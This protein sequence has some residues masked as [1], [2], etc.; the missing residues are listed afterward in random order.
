MGR[1]C[2]HA[3][4]ICWL[5]GRGAQRYRCSQHGEGI[6]CTQFHPNIGLV[7]IIQSYN[8]IYVAVTKRSY[9]A[10]YACVYPLGVNQLS[11]SCSTRILFMFVPMST[12]SQSRINSSPILLALLLVMRWII[13]VHFSNPAVGSHS[14]I[15]E[16]VRLIV[17][18]MKSKDTVCGIALDEYI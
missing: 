2:G 16:V 14:A 12:L 9:N 17:S 4:R 13:F 11:E 15:L 7:I 8:N 10:K 3:A 6:E 1:H 5:V 18:L